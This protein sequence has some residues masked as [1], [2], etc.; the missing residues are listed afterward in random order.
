[1]NTNQAP[2]ESRN[3]NTKNQAP[4]TQAPRSKSPPALRTWSFSGVWCWE[5][6]SPDR[7]MEHSLP[8]AVV[9]WG[10][11]RAR[12]CIQGDTRP[13]EQR[14][15]RAQRPWPAG[16]RRFWLVASLLLGSQSAAAMLWCPCGST[17]RLATSQN[18]LQQTVFY[19]A[20]W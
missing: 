17:S 9:P 19:P 14:S 15:P 6:Y 1:M 8:R 11:A 13:N 2:E 3:R 7:R 20:V 5:L 10:E 12:E 18:R 4:N 16:L